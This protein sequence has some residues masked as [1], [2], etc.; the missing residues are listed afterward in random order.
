MASDFELDA[1]LEVDD[2][3]L[4]DVNNELQVGGD[5]GEMTASQRDS[6]ESVV[7][8]GVSKGVAAAG[9]FG[10]LLSQLKS[11]SGI[12][13]AVL[14]FISRAL[15]PT[16]EVIAD[17]I[18]PLVEGINSFISDPTGAINNAVGFDAVNNGLLQG[19]LENAGFEGT[20]EGFNQGE[21][22]GPSGQL[23]GAA[24]GLGSDLASDLI[25]P[26][27]PDQSGEV[28]KQQQANKNSD[29]LS[30]LLGGF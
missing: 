11:V 13:S 7:A 3:Q 20:A 1:M 14:G 9:I 2:S 26:P 23:A 27:N 15:I 16:V 30:D 6:Q 25:E 22:F 8:G 4:E 28:T 10:A 18:R 12:I 21:S 17:L 29:I 24:L 5:G 19:G